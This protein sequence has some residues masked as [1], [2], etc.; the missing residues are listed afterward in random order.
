MAGWQD[1]KS[2]DSTP[3]DSQR[4]RA[5]YSARAPQ[6]T[7]STVDAARL[8]RMGTDAPPCMA[9]HTALTKWLLKFRGPEWSRQALE[10]RMMRLNQDIRT[11]TLL[12]ETPPEDME[13]ARWLELWE[14]LESWRGQKEALW[15]RLFG[16]PLPHQEP[17]D[18]EPPIQPSLTGATSAPGTARASTSSASTFGTTLDPFQGE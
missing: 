3:K 14:R 17:D 12:L 6:P 9:A 4:S 7:F 10:D 8:S 18:P 13:P 5:K 15:S 2:K 11:L 1:P 16:G